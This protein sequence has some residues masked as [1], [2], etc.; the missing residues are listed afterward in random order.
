[1]AEAV[2]RALQVEV[3]KYRGIQKDYQKLVASR[4]QLDSQLSENQ[5]V[6]AELDLLEDSGNV[7]KLI[8]PVLVKQELQE[9]RHNVEKRIEYISGE[10]KRTD[11]TLEDVESKQ[12]AQR[13]VVAKLQQQLQMKAGGKA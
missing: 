6:K 1:M 13:E 2:Q 4:Q 8:G 5:A 3:E 9:A 7:F 10:L 12:D 11:K